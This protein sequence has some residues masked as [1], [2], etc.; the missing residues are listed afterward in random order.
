[1]ASPTPLPTNLK[2]IRGTAQPCRMNH[3]EPKPKK[4]KLKM[5][6]GLNAEEKRHWRQVVR[7]LEEAGILTLIDVQAL[8]MYCRIYTSW[9]D[10]NKKLDEYGSIVKGTHGTPIISPYVKLS[11]KYFDQL[12]AILR[13]FGMTPSSRSRIHA[14][15]D[16][17]DDDFEAWQKKRRMAREGV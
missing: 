7:D 17:P 6:T 2:V 13:E 15:T 10:A 8:R 5:P 4:G 9:L 14:E 16:K 3:K 1:M 11:Q 12:L